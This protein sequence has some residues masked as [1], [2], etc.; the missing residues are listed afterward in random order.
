M[1]PRKIDNIRNILN[2]LFIFLALAAMVGVVAFPSGS[3]GVMAS[4]YVALLAVV[5]KMIEVC[6]RVP[7]KGKNRRNRKY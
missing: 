5:V 4:Y 7:Q 1:E 3:T 6:F 2:I